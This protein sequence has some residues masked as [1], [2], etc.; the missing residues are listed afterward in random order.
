MNKAIL[1]ITIMLMPIVSYSQEIDNYL[2]REDIG[3][4]KRITKGALICDGGPS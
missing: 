4:Y 2:I 3:S 1:V